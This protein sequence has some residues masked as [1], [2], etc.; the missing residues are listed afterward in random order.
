MSKRVHDIS[1]GIDS[2]IITGGNAQMIEMIFY[3]VLAWF[4]I[5]LDCFLR[6]DFGERY[7]TRANFFIGFWVLNFFFFFLSILVGLGFSGTGS[8]GQWYVWYGYLI[9]S[10]YHF[11]KIWVNAQ[12]GRPQH[13]IYDGTSHLEPVGKFLLKYINPLIAKI[14]MLLGR[15]TLNSDNAKLLKKSLSLSPVFRS[16][17]EFTKMYVEPFVLVLI[18]LFV[19][20]V[21]SLWLTICLIS[22][23]VFT[24]MRYRSMRSD[25]LDVSDGII[26]AATARD[27]KEFQERLRRETRVPRE[28]LKERMEQ[29]PEY[30]QEIKEDNP[31]LLATLEELDLD[32]AFD[33]SEAR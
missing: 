10:A 27:D 31:D 23:I 14:A 17:E 13:S 5:T 6:R 21:P 9:L 28:K 19:P 4:S 25:E 7:Y 26:E 20:S 15:L 3:S 16:P 18:L 32:L 1:G 12:I 29:E 22:H 24:R 11:W 30:E 8:D 33:S 2:S